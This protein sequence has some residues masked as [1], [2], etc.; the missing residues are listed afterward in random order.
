MGSRSEPIPVCPRHNGGSH[1]T[2][3]SAPTALHCDLPAGGVPQSSLA[4]LAAGAGLCPQCEPTAPSPPDRERD[5][6]A[7]SCRSSR[8]LCPRPS[9]SF[10][11]RRSGY[12][13]GCH[14]R[15]LVAGKAVGRMALSCVYA[16]RAPACLPWRHGIDLHHRALFGLDRPLCR[17]TEDLLG[18]RL[19]A[20][21]FRT[22]AA[23]RSGT[24]GRPGVLVAE[25]QNEKG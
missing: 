6:H 8:P 21:L 23:E 7:R 10:S 11:R 15:G 14:Q 4:K 17:S 19:S 25:I 16:P 12:V 18:S 3:S 22:S 13:A 2:L 1:G 20:R 5:A 24:H 9:H